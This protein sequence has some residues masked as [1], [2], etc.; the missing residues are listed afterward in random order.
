MKDEENKKRSFDE[1]LSAFK[2]DSAFIL[3]GHENVL[4]G[5]RLVILIMSQPLRENCMETRQDIARR[6]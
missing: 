6:A 1:K 3:I 2:I 4:A 5:H